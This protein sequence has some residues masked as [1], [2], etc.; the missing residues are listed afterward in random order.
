MG[1]LNFFSRQQNN[2]PTSSF[3]AK[4]YWCEST[5]KVIK[6]GFEYCEKCYIKEKEYLFEMEKKSIGYSEIDKIT[7]KVYLG[8]AEG[9]KEREKLQDLGV[10]HIL[11]CGYFLHEFFPEDFTYKTILLDDSADEN[12]SK[13]FKECLQFIE[14]SDKVYVHC[15]AG[16]SRSS[17]IVIAFLM[18]KNQIGYTE[19]R[20]IVK[21]ARCCIYPNPGFE[22][23]LRNF[24]N[25]L[26]YNS[27]II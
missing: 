3:T 7:E 16:I 9:G 23:Q 2:Q 5:E 20:K 19:A 15:R 21:N 25:Q 4:C 6:A 17:S 14:S 24:D 11:V 10:T 18:W 1:S 26:K 12:I 8:N 27:Y 22:E 13:Y